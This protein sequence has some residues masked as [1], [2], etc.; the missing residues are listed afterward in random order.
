MEKR[1][2]LDPSEFVPF[3]LE[4]R[5]RRE[6]LAALRRQLRRHEHELIVVDALGAIVGLRQVLLEQV[7]E[8]LEVLFF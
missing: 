2:N 5:R 7:P 8:A 3:K 6:K 4:E 1:H